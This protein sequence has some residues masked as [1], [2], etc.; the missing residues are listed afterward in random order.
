MT[1]NLV[2]NSTLLAAFLAL[3][4]LMAG[5]NSLQPLLKEFSSSE[6]PSIEAQWSVQIGEG[7]G[8]YYSRLE[9]VV[10]EKM[11]YAAD[12]QGVVVAI[13]RQ[14][15]E[16]VWKEN[17]N[18]SIGGGLFA[19]YG[20]VL[21]GSSDGELLVLDQDSGKEKW[22]VGLSGEILS[23]PQSN[24]ELI[25]VQ[26]TDGSLYALDAV[27]QAQK[28]VYKT[29]VPVLSLRG[30]ST[31]LIKN[32]QVLAGFANGKFISI[33]VDTGIPKWESVVA[34]PEGRSELERIVDVDGRFV[35]DG[36]IAYVGAYQGKV[37][38]IELSSGRIL[39]K[40]DMSSHVGLESSLSNLY[41][42]TSA[43]ELLA[44][45]QSNGVELWSQDL[46]MDRKP[47]MPVRMGPYIVVADF[48]GYLYW[49][50]QIDGKVVIKHRITG[51][52][53]RDN[54]ISKNKAV[55]QSITRESGNGIRTPV[56]V[57]GNELYIL[58][59]YGELK[60]LTLKK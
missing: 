18:I 51:R 34:L 29:I 3:S 26:T 57:R 33:S 58:N 60:A 9:P 50:S 49:I 23:A 52:T 53:D 4:A 13:D 38:A 47:T 28:W 45:D 59:N 19:G 21:L 16:I 12:P 32:G 41:L 5:C 56:A 30:T 6:G 36:D 7:V 39:W 35:V 48:E 14:S 44:L 42:A 24:G 20:L 55:Y 54:P 22:R 2:K 46:L 43:G 25:V 40:K 17:L 10:T 11:I 27:T 37:V 1:K 15:G 31:P 8:K